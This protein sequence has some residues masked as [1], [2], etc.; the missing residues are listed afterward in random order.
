MATAR[1]S[2]SYKMAANDA[3][4]PRAN[5][6]AFFRL[7]GN[8]ITNDC[9]FC[10]FPIPHLPSAF[11]S[12]FSFLTRCFLSHSL[13][14]FPLPHSFA[15]FH[16]QRRVTPTATAAVAAAAGHIKGLFYVTCRHRFSEATRAKFESWSCRS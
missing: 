2:S 3:A 4:N 12:H 9:P 1:A 5:S 14:G 13:F 15:T 10:T 16:C 6:Q 7:F 8:E 11:L